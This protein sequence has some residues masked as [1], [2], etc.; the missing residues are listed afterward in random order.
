MYTQKYLK[1]KEKYIKLK[2]NIINKQIGGF[3]LNDNSVNYLKNDVIT[4]LKPHI[5]NFD[6][7]GAAFG[8]LVI[9]FFGFVFSLDWLRGLKSKSTSENT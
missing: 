9:N 3:F 7:I 1:Y 6:I 8:W 4:N 2:N 5:V